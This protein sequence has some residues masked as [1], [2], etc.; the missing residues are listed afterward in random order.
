MNRTGIE[1]RLGDRPREHCHTALRGTCA[2]EG[3]GDGGADKVE[4][5]EVPAAV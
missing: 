3:D 2:R 4:G 1:T 5:L